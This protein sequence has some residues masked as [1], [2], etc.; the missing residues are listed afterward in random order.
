MPQAVRTGPVVPVP[1]PKMPQMPMALAP[2]EQ[3]GSITADDAFFPPPAGVTPVPT[4][5]PFVPGPTEPQPAA[6][7]A[8]AGPSAPPPRVTGP[9]PTGPQ[10]PTR[11]TLDSEAIAALR[12]QAA[13]QAEERRAAKRRLRI[14]SV[15]LVLVVVGAGI[16]AGLLLR[17]RSAFRAEL[18]GDLVVTHRAGDYTIEV[19]VRTSEPSVVVHPAGSQAVTEVGR[20]TF[21]LPS[22]EMHV[23]DNTVGLTVRANGSDDEQLLTLHVLVYYRLRTEIIPPPR[24]GVPIKAHV[25]LM[26][27]WSL[28][29]EGG[30]SARIANDTYEVQIDPGP[31]LA[32][33]DTMAGDTV[34]LP[35][36]LVLRDPNGKEQTFTEVLQVPIPATPITVLRPP[37]GWISDADKVRVGGRTVP[38]AEVTVA[39]QL[40]KIDAGGYFDVQVPLGAPGRHSIEIVANGPKKRAGRKSISLERLT[41]AAFNAARGGLRSEAATYE[42]DSKAPTYTSLVEDPEPHRGQ[43][44][45]LR[46]ELLDARRGREGSV[47]TLQ[48]ATCKVKSRCPYWVELSGPMMAGP[49][50]MVEVVGTLDGNSTYKT[51]SGVALTVPRLKAEF[52]VP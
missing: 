30:V 51:H 44:I 28:T 31:L 14:A 36:P 3:V 33:V 23:G 32:R 40:V 41:E 20:V 52:L 43:K 19:G 17:Q 9:R 11:G 42:V 47:D 35:I 15:L 21:S 4:S 7:A 5:A 39:G 45:R 13:S 26:P 50:D 38:G 27:D 8:Q 1:I 46:G 16:A 18:E 34:A 37:H 10:G 2:T 29:V 12:I 25:E 6:Q 24:P 49:G 48:L 22:E